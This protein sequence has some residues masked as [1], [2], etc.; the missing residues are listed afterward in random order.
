[1]GSAIV[2]AARIWEISCHMHHDSPHSIHQPFAD[3]FCWGEGMRIRIAMYSVG[4]VVFGAF[5]ALSGSTLKSQAFDEKTGNYTVVLKTGENA[6]L[7][8]SEHESD[9]VDVNHV[10]SDGVDSG[11]VASMSTE[12][13]NELL[14]DS[15]VAYVSRNGTMTVHRTWMENMKL[16]IDRQV[17]SVF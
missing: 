4:I 8:S 7:I 14:A 6:S 11:Y 16:T 5:A 15:R 9:G 17:S 12:K 1:M 10:T 3:V 13:A 2:G